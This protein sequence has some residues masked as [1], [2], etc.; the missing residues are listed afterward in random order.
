MDV[1]AGLSTFI[2]VWLGLWVIPAAVP[3]ASAKAPGNFIDRKTSLYLLML[4]SMNVM[5]V[6]PAEGWSGTLIIKVIVLSLLPFVAACFMLRSYY[7]RS[8]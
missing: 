4:I 2:S 8:H 1:F 3:Q 6:F 5:V 7:G